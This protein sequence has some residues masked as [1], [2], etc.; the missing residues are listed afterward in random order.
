MDLQLFAEDDWVTSEKSNCV[1]NLSCIFQVDQERVNMFIHFRDTSQVKTIWKTIH[2]DLMSSIK[3]ICI[4]VNQSLLL[5]DL[6]DRRMCNRLL[7]QAVC[8]CK[9]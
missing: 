1:S 3:D 6:Y 4:Q 9:S 7:E 8:H 2:Q 5:N